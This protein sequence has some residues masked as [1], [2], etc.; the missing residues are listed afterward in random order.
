[1]K[2]GAHC[3]H[4]HFK[5][6]SSPSSGLVSQN[7]KC[8][9]C[10]KTYKKTLGLLKHYR[11]VH[12][13]HFAVD[14]KPKKAT[15]SKQ[16]K[17]S[18]SKS[19]KKSACQ[20][21]GYR[22]K[23]CSSMFKTYL[24][25]KSH[26]KRFRKCYAKQFRCGFCP[27]MYTS[28][29]SLKQ[30][31]HKVHFHMIK[32][33]NSAASVPMEKVRSTDQLPHE[34]CLLHAC[35]RCR[36]SFWSELELEKHKSN[37]QAPVFKCRWCLKTF[38][39]LAARYQHHVRNHAELYFKYWCYICRKGFLK[40]AEF[41]KHCQ[42]EHPGPD[43][44]ASDVKAKTA[45]HQ[46]SHIITTR[47][48]PSDINIDTPEREI[49]QS[50]ISQQNYGPHKYV[51]RLCDHCD[52]A[53]WS[54]YEWKKH[55]RTL[56]TCHAAGYKCEWCWT[57]FQTR[58]ARHKHYLD[59]H[60]HE[61]CHCEKRYVRSGDLINHLLKVHPDVYARNEKSEGKLCQ[62]GTT[63]TN[64]NVNTDEQS[65]YQTSLTGYGGVLRYW[66][67]MCTTRCKT[68]LLLRKHYVKRHSK[69]FNRVACGHCDRSFST[70]AGLKIH[71]QKLHTNAELV[72]D[73]EKLLNKLT[74]TQITEIDSKSNESSNIEELPPTSKVP[75]EIDCPRLCADN[76]VNVI[77]I[78]P[79]P[80]CNETLTRSDKSTV[81]FEDEIQ[82]E[83]LSDL[84]YQQ[85]M[86]SSNIK[87]FCHDDS[88]NG[89]TNVANVYSLSVNNGNSKGGNNEKHE[90][91]PRNN[92][93]FQDDPAS[94]DMYNSDST[95]L[96][97]ETEQELKC[98]SA[99]VENDKKDNSHQ[100]NTIKIE[101]KIEMK[102]FD[103]QQNNINFSASAETNI[104]PKSES[105]GQEYPKNIENVKQEYSK[106][107]QF[108]DEKVLIHICDKNVEA[109][110][111]ISTDLREST[112]GVSKVNT[113]VKN[114]TGTFRNFTTDSKKIEVLPDIQSTEK[115]SGIVK[116]DDLLI[117]KEN[118]VELERLYPFRCMYCDERHRDHEER[119]KHY[120]KQHYMELDANDFE[121]T[122]LGKHLKQV[123][124]RDCLQSLM[125]IIM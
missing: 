122:G 89:L 37:C 21:L 97:D 27:A 8:Q 121:G 59:V 33:N 91:K 123:S 84:E 48:D 31:Y 112:E 95:E 14:E 67:S 32:G 92:L 23:I 35:T 72:C 77:E 63:Q 100:K 60:F 65:S 36:E 41:I 19:K 70:Q 11:Q 56:A 26:Y 69:K 78:K 106:E 105:I 43:Q 53:F 108:K 85:A 17:I 71:C 64:V 102:G 76:K 87:D 12:P 6:L 50:R 61:C 18:R 125:S 114:S 86:N 15:K 45:E 109:I 111:N 39:T 49:S 90:E 58:A 30:H 66:C 22:C 47:Q 62:N 98:E 113:D 40:H 2:L 54:E 68:S 115:K 107:S 38:L 124:V 28:D 16:G 118:D 24:D 42:K 75:S 104:V 5:T 79:I 51:L 44:C 7:M 4:S 1:M 119:G 9:Y 46:T 101:S 93:T 83:M 3:Q 94:V 117:N 74:N 29:A 88:P 99:A 55:Q 13:F 52:K 34:R 73:R 25:L 81:N 57:S 10:R 103:T 80:D 110:S 82:R 96:S 120:L 116:P 20:L